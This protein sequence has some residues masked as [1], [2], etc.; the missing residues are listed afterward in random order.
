MAGSWPGPG[1]FP[2]THIAHTYLTRPRSLNVQT[3][4]ELREHRRRQ[5][6]GEDVGVLRARRNMKNTDIFGGNA[7]M[8]K[9]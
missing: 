6:F 3:G 9:V 4:P 8:N 5:A 2:Y 7:L 1:V